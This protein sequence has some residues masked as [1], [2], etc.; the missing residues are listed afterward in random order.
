MLT[1][2]YKPGQDAPPGTRAAEARQNL[3]I[4]QLYWTEEYKAK[5]QELV[6]IAGDFG[7]GAA[8]LAIA[9]TLKNPNVSSVIL[10]TS[11]VAQLQQN[12][13]ALDVR[14]TD[15]VVA[16]LEELYPAP[17]PIPAV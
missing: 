1:G 17:E 16:K 13:K 8:E 11:S 6:K 9:W 3:V 7:V 15:D 10:G 14:L 5:G 12:L 4:K 2:K